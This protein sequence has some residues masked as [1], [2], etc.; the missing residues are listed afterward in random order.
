MKHFLIIFPSLLLFAFLSG[1]ATANPGNSS[2][3]KQEQ[4]RFQKHLD[5]RYKL[6]RAGANYTVEKTPDNRWIRKEYY[7]E[8]GQKTREITYADP[9]LWTA[10]GAAREWYDN[11][12]LWAEGAYRQNKKAGVW[13][14][15]EFDNAAYDTGPYLAGLKQGL[16]T[17]YDSA[18]VKLR[19][20]AYAADKIVKIT[21]FGADSWQPTTSGEW[22]TEPA[23]PCDTAYVALGEKCSERSLL[24][25]LTRNIQYPALARENDIQGVAYVSFTVDK[26]GSVQNV[27]VVRGLCNGIKAQCQRVMAI[28]PRWQPGQAGGKPVRVRFTQP[29]RFKLE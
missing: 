18:G 7:F 9:T 27:Q 10:E 21:T 15:Y 26:D 22:Q 11:G 14:E 25:F 2:T 23:Y 4:N 29:V 16:W 17:S 24:V 19:E 8:T 5:P 3:Q 6:V 12:K 28:M 13:T 20:T 1:C